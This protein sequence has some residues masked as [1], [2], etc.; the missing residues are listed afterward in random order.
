MIYY[1]DAVRKA[2]R[3]GFLPKEIFTQFNHVFLALSVVCDF[4]MFDIKR[5][6][7]SGERHYYR[8]RKGKYRAIFYRKEQDFYVTLIAKRE[9][10]YTLWESHP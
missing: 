10:V 1:E 2:I 3:K 4:S 9:E 7:S 5:L 8:L 6:K